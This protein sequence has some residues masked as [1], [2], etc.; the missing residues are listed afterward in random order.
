M[1]AESLWLVKAHLDLCY[2]LPAMTKTRTFHFNRTYDWLGK[3]VRLVPMFCTG[4]ME[5]YEDNLLW[6]YDEA[7]PDTS[8]H[9]PSRLLKEV[10]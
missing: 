1:N 7:D 10:T 3:K 9:V 5:C 6:C 2:D 8:F 4:T